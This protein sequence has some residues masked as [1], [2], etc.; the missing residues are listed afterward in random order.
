M[1]ILYG[2]CADKFEQKSVKMYMCL[3][4]SQ[5]EKENKVTQ[6]KDESTIN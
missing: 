4:W 1:S 2:C 3:E 5:N 6:K